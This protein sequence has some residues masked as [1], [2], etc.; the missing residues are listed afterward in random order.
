MISRMERKIL[1]IV[2]T[3]MMFV[4]T[5]YTGGVTVNAAD[6]EKVQIT[7][8]SAGVKIDN[9]MVLYHFV[10]QETGKYHFHSIESGDTQGVIL[11]SN[12]QILKDA[13]DDG[14]ANVDF[15]IKMELTADESYYLGVDYY[16]DIEEGKIT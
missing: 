12:K 2:L 5:I 15:S 1:A 7:E 9:D 10:P 8:I 11:D 13:S 3:V 6:F 14:Q 4:T 16:L